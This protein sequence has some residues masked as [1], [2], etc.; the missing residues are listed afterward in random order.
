MADTHAGSWT[1]GGIALPDFGLTEAIGGNQTSQGGSNIIP[2]N[3]QGAVNIGSQL[4]GSPINIGSGGTSGQVKGTSTSGGG[5]GGGG[6]PPPAPTG[7]GSGGK[8]NGGW[9]N[10]VQYWAPGQG[11]TS[12]APTN[13][14]A[15]TINWDDQI[16]AAYQPAIDALNQYQGVL[17]Q[18][19]DTD[20]ANIGTNVA[21]QSAKLDTEKQQLT[22]DAQTQQNTFNQQLQSALQDAI[23]S[24]NA[25]R[26]Q[27]NARFGN[28]SSAGG[29]VGELA[30]QEFFRQQGNTQQQQAQG[31]SQFATEFNRIG[32]FISQAKNDLDTYKNQAID[33]IKQNLAQNLNQIAQ[34]RGTIEANK[35]NARLGVLQNAQQQAAAI[36]AAD[37]QYRQNLVTSTL[38]SM[39]Q[40]AGR[41]FTP[42][43]IQT[44]L[45]ALQNAIF[46]SAGNLQ[47]KNAQQ[48]PLSMVNTLGTRK[49]ELNSLG[50][51][52]S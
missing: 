32:T 20:I 28:G 46:G 35:T 30:A 43:E 22:E 3:I 13:N 34:Q 1:F 39:Q 45:A 19:A 37:T 9:Y 41:V 8:Q 16:S 40:A 23:R 38:S 52:Q 10:G 4:A 44:N 31:N 7:G 11:P 26:Q 48:S 5:G 15:P 49:D 42:T 27:G 14:T 25:L 18:G 24:Y 17:G 2:N 33:S 29:A 6:T 36:Q 50:S 51:V 21:N 12:N 47:N